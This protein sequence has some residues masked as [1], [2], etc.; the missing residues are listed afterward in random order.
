VVRLV[1]TGSSLTRRPKRSLRCLRGNFAINEQNYKL[2]RRIVSDEHTLFTVKRV[3][4]DEYTL[5]TVRRV[6]S[7]E[8]R[9]FS[10][11]LRGIIVSCVLFFV[12][13]GIFLENIDETGMDVSSGETLAIVISTS[14]IF[15]V[16]MQVD[17]IRGWI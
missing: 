3:V 14:L 10:S 4:S 5:L 1:V 9:L 15:V 2:L 17:V 7:D 12:P 16:T 8:H 6:V 13:Y 11:G